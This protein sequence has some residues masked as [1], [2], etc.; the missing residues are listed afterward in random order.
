MTDSKRIM[1]F[2]DG[3]NFYYSL[4]KIFLTTKI[5]FKKFIDFSIEKKHHVGFSKMKSYH[6]KNIYN[7]TIKIE[8]ISKYML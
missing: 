3:S 5:Y 4:K 2:I 8:D 7:N 6:L 1:V